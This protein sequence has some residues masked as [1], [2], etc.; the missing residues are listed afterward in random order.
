LYRSVFGSFEA[1]SLL[2]AWRQQ[3]ATRHQI[4]ILSKLPKAL[5]LPWELLHDEQGFLVRRTRKPVSLVRRLPQGEQASQVISFEPPLRILLVTA[6]PEG[7]GFIDPRSIARELLDEVQ[8][9]VEQGTIA[10]EM[11]RPPTLSA[12]RRRLGD[13]KRPPI[14]ILHFDGHGAFR[15]DQL[16]QNGLVLSGTGEGLLAFEDDEGKLDLVQ[17][18]TV[19]QVLL[20]HR[21]SFIPPVSHV[22]HW[23]NAD[24]S[25]RKNP[26]RTQGEKN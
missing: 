2:Q 25:S 24:S 1:I 11:L 5:S 9:Q 10:V 12:L 23:E 6:R 8:E 20:G 15:P 17:A 18:E 3:A 16:S 4:S 26:R 19:A 22:D 13:P 7:T 21:P 14:H